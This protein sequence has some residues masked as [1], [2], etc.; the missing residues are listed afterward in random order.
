VDPLCSGC[1]SVVLLLASLPVS[2]LDQIVRQAIT[3][4]LTL[5][6]F[7]ALNYKNL[8][9][10]CSDV[11]SKSQK[12]IEEEVKYTARVVIETSRL[13]KA[14]KLGA[15]SVWIY[16]F[17][18]ALH[19]LNIVIQLVLMSHFVGYGAFDWAVNVCFSNFKV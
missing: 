9:D 16:M 1:A 14:K 13:N 11:Q 15:L 7:L 3:L 12:D 8:V 19:I 18:K 2:D 6:N 5:Y 4:I 17:S 10:R